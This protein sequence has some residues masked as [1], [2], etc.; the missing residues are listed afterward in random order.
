MINRERDDDG[1]SGDAFELLDDD[2]D[3]DENN[4]AED[5]GE[6][7]KEDVEDALPSILFMFRPL[8]VPQSDLSGLSYKWITLGASGVLWSRMVSTNT[9]MLSVL[10]CFKPTQPIEASRMSRLGEQSM[11]KGGARRSKI[12]N[13]LLEQGENVVRKD[14][15]NMIQKHKTRVSNYDDDEEAAAVIARF[16]TECETGVV[17]LTTSHMRESFARFS[18]F[19]MVETTHKTNRYN[20]QLYILMVMNE[21]GEGQAVQPSLLERNPYW[22]MKRAQN[23]FVR[24]NA[25]SVEDVHVIMVDT[26]MNEIR[27]R[28]L[29][30]TFQVIKY[31]GMMSRK[32]DFEEFPLTTMWLSTRRDA[33][34]INKDE[35]A[36]LCEE[37]DFGGFYD[38]F[39]KNW[40]SCQGM[41]VWH[42]RSKLERFFGKL[43]LITQDQGTMAECL[44]GIIGDERRQREYIHRKLR[45]GTNHNGNLHEEMAQYAAALTKWER[46]VFDE[47]SEPG[48]MLVHAKQ[49]SFKVDLVD[50]SCSC[51]CSACIKLP[52]QHAIAIRKHKS[53][54]GHLIPMKRID[55]RYMLSL[56]F[57]TGFTGEVKPLERFR[58]TTTSRDV[59]TKRSRMT[60]EKYSEALRQTK[61]MCSEHADIENDD[62]FQEYLT[63]IRH[64]WRN[65]N[66]D[67]CSL[68]VAK[69]WGETAHT[70]LPTSTADRHPDSE[71]EADSTSNVDSDDLQPPQSPIRLNPDAKKTGRLQV[72][73][74]IRAT[75]ER[76]VRLRFNAAERLKTELGDAT[77]EQV[78]AGIATDKPTLNKILRRTRQIPE[79][80][81]KHVIR[82]PKFEVKQNPVLNVNAFYVLP[83]KLLEVCLKKFPANTVATAIRLRSQ[84]SQSATPA[85]S[86][87]TETVKITGPGSFS[88]AQINTMMSISLARETAENALALKIWLETDV[89]GA[90]IEHEEDIQALSEAVSTA[91]PFAL[92]PNLAVDVSFNI[93]YTFRPPEWFRDGVIT[94]FCERLCCRLPRIKAYKFL[95]AERRQRNSEAA[96]Q[97][98]VL[99]AISAAMNADDTIV[100]VPVHF[101]NVHWGG[102]IIDK[103]ARTI[104]NYESMLTSLNRSA[105]EHICEHASPIQSDGRSSGYFVCT[106]VWRCVEDD[107]SR[108]MSATGQ[109]RMRARMLKFI[110]H[111]G[112]AED[113]QA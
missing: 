20:Y 18:E 47:A 86:D 62:E 84:S 15:D 113:H 76:L 54:D 40:D 19:V 16:A 112:A 23:H 50:W 109:L 12:Y 65:E 34:Q 82:K 75:E 73:R 83:R 74:S 9:T 92:I 81:T 89:T 56:S 1:S 95:S 91:Y 51:D 57:P 63:Y 24:V 107:L 96:V 27:A 101:N 22:H 37:V 80:R 102:I 90:C 36:S 3:D 49:S 94:A 68:Q 110:L 42:P 108:D 64:Q 13:F 71:N 104:Y 7:S 5:A 29:I 85:A 87:T 43:K 103:E 61:E 59:N 25:A 105:L 10:K 39:V 67:P 58:Y 14:V 77:L 45:L 55:R 26:D 52:C 99:A 21:C 60:C 70:Q 46:R 97:E 17:F 111:R 88:R 11:I 2:F 53:K 41:W 33:Y 78:A 8:N 35:L 48:F 32:P 4:A 69:T 72:D 93:L 66:L 44:K 28:M 6:V 38:Y 31:L 100:V 98:D 106:R 79:N 30:G